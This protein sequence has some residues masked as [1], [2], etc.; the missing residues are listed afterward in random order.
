MKSF[1]SVTPTASLTIRA[2]NSL[3]WDC[4]Q[5]LLIQSNTQDHRYQDEII[6]FLESPSNAIT[7]YEQRVGNSFR[8]YW[9][10]QGDG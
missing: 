1:Q 8:Q 3:Q 2:L 4:S 10:R 9:P 5:H 7:D 6:Q